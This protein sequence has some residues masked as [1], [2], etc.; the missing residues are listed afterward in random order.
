MSTKNSKKS[1]NSQNYFHIYN[2][3]VEH[4]N[5]F[6]DKKDFEV[7]LNY[8][9]EYLTPPPGTDQIKKT[10]SV[11]GRTFQGI[12]HQPKNYFNKVELIAYSLMPDHFHL[13]VRQKL[14]G[15]L[16][17]LIRSICTRYA[18]Y[19]NKKYHRSGSLFSGPYKKVDIADVSELLYLTR[20]FHLEP[21]HNKF[22]TINSIDYVYTSYPDYLGAR[23]TSWLNTNLVLSY[24]DKSY[25]KNSIEKGDY[26]KFVE[27]YELNQ[28]EKKILE[29]IIFKCIPKKLEKRDLKAQ[30]S[31]SFKDVSTKPVSKAKSKIPE[32]AFLSTAI[33]IV[34]F[35]V[36]FRNV[37]SSSVEMLEPKQE[38][39]VSSPETTP[40]PQVSGLKDEKPTSKNILVITLDD[41]S[42][43]VNIRKEPTT[44]S[45]I[46]GRAKD[47]DTFEFI[48]KVSGW[49]Q[50]KLDDGA[51]FVSENLVMVKEEETN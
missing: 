1:D 26:K 47:G 36:G 48:S 9:K 29:R 45:E 12:P 37:L 31:E 39:V 2:K 35:S 5:L 3:V 51:A 49:Y 8:L 24:F 20:F 38:S 43:S 16:E 30:E 40:T 27:T 46:V 19:Y 41:V 10:F 32:F 28:N 6:N 23:N 17:K 14:P 4:R 34:L 42:S 50:I 7:F 21:L 33:F 18:I 11:K 15:T 44:D 13:L 25:N 22:K